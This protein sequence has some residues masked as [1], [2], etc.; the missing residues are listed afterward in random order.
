MR[1]KEIH[2]KSILSPSKV[3][4]CIIYFKAVGNEI[5]K[6][7]RRLGIDCRSDY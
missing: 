2:A 7:C 6:D 4:N 1:I 5:E 3:Y